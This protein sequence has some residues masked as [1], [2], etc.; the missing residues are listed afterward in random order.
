MF[1]PLRAASA[2]AV[3]VLLAAG[4][5]AGAA[6]DG[7]V[8]ITGAYARPVPAGAVGAAYLEIENPSSTADRLLSLA[9]TVG[10]AEV[11]EMKMDG[12]VMRM[13]KIASLEIPAHATIRFAPGGFHVMLTHLEHPLAAGEHFQLHLQFERTGEVD[14]DVPVEQR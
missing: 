9:S 7:A 8:R 2:V 11:H 4:T 14:V 1:S 6:S 10:T 13:R 5:G 12:D 3:T